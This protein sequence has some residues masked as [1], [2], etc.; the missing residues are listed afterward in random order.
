MT[1]NIRDQQMANMPEPDRISRFSESDEHDRGD[2]IMKNVTSMADEIRRLRRERAAACFAIMRAVYGDSL[3]STRALFGDGRIYDGTQMTPEELAEL[4]REAGCSRMRDGCLLPDDCA[5]LYRL[6][7]LAAMQREAIIERAAMEAGIAGIDI[8]MELER[9]ACAIICDR[10]G[11]TLGRI[12]A[13]KIRAR[14][15]ETE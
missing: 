7:E 5:Q 10:H 14:E 11:L 8:A 9:E 3:I 6:V 12:L 4:A 13:Q 2:R 15:H 1:M